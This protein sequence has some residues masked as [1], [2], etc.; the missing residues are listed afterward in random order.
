M[1]KSAYL[2]MKKVKAV[3]RHKS[4]LVFLLLCIMALILSPWANA[5]SPV[6]PYVPE[7]E[8]EAIA[9][10]QPFTP[11]VFSELTV[12]VGMEEAEFNVL[13]GQNEA[14]MLRHPD[15]NIDLIRVEPAQAYRNFVLS[16]QLGD[17]ADIILLANEWVREFASSGYL[18][19]ADAAFVGK[20]LAEQFDAL[21]APL[22]WNG[23]LW[24]VPRSFDP[25]VVIWNIDMLH[26]WL[27]GDV[28]L[29][30]TIEQWSALATK[31]SELQGTPSWLTLDPSDPLAL[32]AW[33][34]NVSGGRSD[35]IWS[36]GSRPWEGTPFEQGLTLLEQQ[37]SNITFAQTTEQA[38]FSLKNR[39]T[40]A[41]IIPYSKAATLAAEPRL[42][43]D[44]KLE[45]DHRTWKLPYVWPRGS[46]FVISSHTV[47]ED[48]AH[49]WIAEMTDIPIQLQNMEEL[50]RLPVYRTL[51]ESDRQLS[52][53]LPDREGKAFPNQA[54][55]NIGPKLSEQLK[56]LGVIWNSFATGEITLLE[57]NKRWAELIANHQLDN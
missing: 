25:F 23:Y 32:L 20:A 38:S 12:E 27:G 4:A 18:L 41:A 52:N 5:P 14:F 44:A 30:L 11:M 42:S 9:S 46:S 53:L 22:K 6:S 54:S 34:E 33:L 16:S 2:T 1:N 36:K 55:M 7:F 47:V 28:V 39:E 49:T 13:A 21:A 51:Y 50:N 45:L 17:S 56:E 37:R 15:I 10:A 3:T 24:G 57:W 29:P 19:P 31:S 35:G 8:A 26:E 48:A 40:L 43:S